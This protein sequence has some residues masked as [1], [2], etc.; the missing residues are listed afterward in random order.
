[1]IRAAN[2]AAWLGG[3]A[4]VLAA[5]QAQAGLNVCNRTSYRVETAIGLEK[6][7]NVA[8]RGWYKL[9]PGECKQV[10]DGTLDADMVYVHSRTPQIYG[11]SPAPESGQAEL[12][13]RDGD[14]A[15]ADGRNCPLSQQLRFS[16]ARPSDTPDGPTVY[17]AEQAGYDDAQARLAGIQRLLAIA[18][19]DAYPIDGVAGGKTQSAIAKFLS[20]RKL[21]A[22]AADKPNFFDALLEAARNP[23]GA[24]F[25]WCNDTT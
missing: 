3:L 11:T 10:L 8:T 4:L 20:D 2:G 15:I 5:T 18:G 24:G 1:M 7:P 22:D 12:C 6:Q 25:A 16:A 23:Q 19:Y 17:L 21:A 9:D 13:V 14:F